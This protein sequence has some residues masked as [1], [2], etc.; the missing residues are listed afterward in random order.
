M[1]RSRSIFL[2]SKSWCAKWGVTCSNFA[3][4]DKEDTRIPV[5]RILQK[6]LVNEP[7][8]ECRSVHRF[9]LFPSS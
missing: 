4:F 7:E 2:S 8:L 9:S 6:T 1:K 3:Q 5:F